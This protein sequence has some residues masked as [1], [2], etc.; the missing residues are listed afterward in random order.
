MERPRPQKRA[1]T[2][3]PRGAIEAATSAARARNE[4]AAAIEATTAPGKVIV[5]TYEDTLLSKIFADSNVN[6]LSASLVMQRSDVGEDTCRLDGYVHGSQ[7]SENFHHRV[8]TIA[9]HLLQGEIGGRIPQRLIDETDAMFTKFALSTFIP[10]Q[11]RHIEIEAYTYGQLVEFFCAAIEVRTATVYQHPDGETEIH[12]VIEEADVLDD[13]FEQEHNT[14]DELDYIAFQRAQAEAVR[15]KAEAD[16]VEDAKNRR[17]MTEMSEVSIHL[18][19]LK[20]KPIPHNE[21]RFTARGIAVFATIKGLGIC[22]PTMQL[23][24]TRNPTGAITA[25]V[26]GYSNAKPYCSELRDRVNDTLTGAGNPHTSGPP[27]F[28]VSPTKISDPKLFQSW[29]GPFYFLTHPKKPSDSYTATCYGKEAKMMLGRLHDLAPMQEGESQVRALV[30]VSYTGFITVSISNLALPEDFYRIVKG[31]VTK[32]YRETEGVMEPDEKEYCRKMEEAVRK[33]KVDEMAKELE[34]EL[35]REMSMDVGEVEVARPAEVA[36]AV[37]EEKDA[38]HAL[39]KKDHGVKE[40]N[41]MID[42]KP[43]KVVLKVRPR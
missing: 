43:R 23:E 3:H 31:A 15:I 26:T 25:E 16:A 30:S 1:K 17:K 33:Q 39:K 29:I 35:E 27:N 18:E 11:G 19:S 38:N 42:V 10:S 5:A 4:A 34:E 12:C 9:K 8:S 40:E 6:S 2:S 36:D 21:K 24:I 20:A 41:F 14:Q 7:P 28:G 37:D 22:L 32:V 13:K